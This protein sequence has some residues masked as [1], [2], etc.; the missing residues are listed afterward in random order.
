MTDQREDPP[1]EDEE[2]IEAQ[3]T[4]TPPAPDSRTSSYF[5]KLIKYIPGDLVAGYLAL[6]GILRE[7]L[8]GDPVSIWLYWAVF[9]TILILTPFY[10]KFR[11]SQQAQEESIRF[12]CCAA[13]VAFTTWVFALGGPFA[14]TWPG[15]YRPVYGSLL[16]VI[17]ALAI[18]VIEAAAMKLKFFNPRLEERT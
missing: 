10:V 4:P 12:H 8:I 14:V 3:E 9:G 13:T 7:E 18:P 1:V 17:T 2:T 6:D 16:L 11:P 15:I 5:E